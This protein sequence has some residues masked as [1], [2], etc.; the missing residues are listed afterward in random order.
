MDRLVLRKSKKSI[1]MESLAKKRLDVKCKYYLSAID[2]GIFV[3]D[4]GDF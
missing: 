4:F 2:R 1:G 3:P